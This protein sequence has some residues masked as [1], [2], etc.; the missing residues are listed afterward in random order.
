MRAP[1]HSNACMLSSPRFKVVIHD[2]A[3]VI[4]NIVNVR[5]C[6]VD[7]VIDNNSNP[8]NYQKYNKRDKY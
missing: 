2:G 4:V 6:A 1:P 8:R 5:Q 7:I 3:R